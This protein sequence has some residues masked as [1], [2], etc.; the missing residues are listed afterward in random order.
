MKEKKH[1]PV[2]LKP[3]VYAGSSRFKKKSFLGKKNFF[4]HL[5]K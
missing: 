1:S 3:C 5:E 4:V 2:S